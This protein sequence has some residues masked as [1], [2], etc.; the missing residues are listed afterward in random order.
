MHRFTFFITLFVVLLGCD[1]GQPVSVTPRD[2]AVV[3]DQAIDI[4]QDM[5][6]MSIDAHVVDMETADAALPDYV[7][8]LE[9]SVQPA[10]KIRR[11]QALETCSGYLWRGGRAWQ[12]DVVIRRSTSLTNEEQIET[13]IDQSEPEFLR[14][15]PPF[16]EG[17]NV[18]DRR[19]PADEAGY[20]IAKLMI[21]GAACIYRLKSTRHCRWHLMRSDLLNMTSDHRSQ[22]RSSCGRCVWSSAVCAAVYPRDDETCRS[23]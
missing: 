9:P 10:P 19:R 11:S 5:P 13:L 6:D 3:I 14:F 23:T 7:Q 1:P 2:A 20:L 12:R 4:D 16:E 21:L 17:M 22:Q 18:L 15:V 8:E